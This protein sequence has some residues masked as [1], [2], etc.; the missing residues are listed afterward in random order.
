MADL[1]P[2]SKASSLLSASPV[3]GSGDDNS[4]GDGDSK[5]GRYPKIILGY[6]IN[7]QDGEHE[8]ET[9]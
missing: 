9:Q 7:T 4:S 1:E 5:E 6:E 3:L 8:T 2:E